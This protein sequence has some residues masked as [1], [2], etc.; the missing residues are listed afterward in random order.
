MA[1]A[2]PTTKSLKL[3][4]DQG[5]VCAIVERWNAHVGI[6]QDLFGFID[7]LGVG[8]NGTL[9]IQTT[10]IGEFTR[11]IK[12]ITGNYIPKDDKELNRLLGVR[13]KAIACLSAGWVIEVHGWDQKNPAAQPRV[14]RITLGDLV[15]TPF[16]EEPEKVPF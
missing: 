16:S 5:Y 7:I 2:T 1:K 3:A 8:P 14:Q 4:R 11:R 13:E 12:K 15:T 10:S 9:A 6:R